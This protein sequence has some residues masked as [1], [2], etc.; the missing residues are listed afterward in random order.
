MDR[1]L[2]V[3]LLLFIRISNTQA[4]IKPGFPCEKIPNFCERVDCVPVDD[5]TTGVLVNGGGNC[6]C[7]PICVTYQ[8]LEESCES[9]NKDEDPEYDKEFIGLTYK[10][11][12][13]CHPGMVCDKSGTKQCYLFIRNGNI[14]NSECFHR[15]AVTDDDVWEVKPDCDFY[16]NFELKRNKGRDTPRTFCVDEDGETIF[17]RIPTGF[18]N[19]TCACS[20][21]VN[22][23]QMA[24]NLLAGNVRCDELGDFT[25]LQCW[26]GVCFCVDPYTKEMTTPAIPMSGISALPCYN[27]TI[28]GDGYYTLCQSELYKWKAIIEELHNKGVNGTLI[29]LPECDFD[30]TYAAMQYDGN[31]QICATRD[32]VQIGSFMHEGVPFV[33][34]NCRCARDSVY[35]DG[36]P[37]SY[38]FDDC[39]NIGE[40]NPQ[41][42]VGEDYYCLDSDGQQTNKSDL[43]TYFIRQDNRDNHY[44]NN[45]SDWEMHQLRRTRRKWATVAFIM[46]TYIAIHYFLMTNHYKLSEPSELTLVSTSNWTHPR[47]KCSKGKVSKEKELL[48]SEIQSTCPYSSFRGLNQK[49]ISYSFY[50]DTDSGYFKGIEI[51]T[52]S[53]K[54]LYPGWTVRLYHDIRPEDVKGMN[55]LCEIVCK[56]PHLDEC[57]VGD[58]NDQFSQIETKFGMLWRFLVLGDPSVDVFGVRDLDSPV[59]EREIDAVNDW[60]S[61]NATFHIMRD[62]PAHVTYILGGMWGARNTNDI[63]KLQKIRNKIITEA[64]SKLKSYDQGLLSMYVWPEAINDMTTVTHRDV[65]NRKD[66]SGESI[67]NGVVKATKI[68]KSSITSHLFLIIAPLLVLFLDILCLK[69]NDDISKW[70]SIP[71]NVSAYINMESIVI[72]VSWIAIQLILF[73]APFGQL[74]EIKSRNGS[75]SKYRVNGFLAFTVISISI[76]LSVYFDF[77]SYLL[78]ISKNSLSFNILSCI[79]SVT[80]AIYMHKKN[81]NSKSDSF[82]TDDFV[83]GEHTRPSICGWD[84]K[85]LLIRSSIIS[86]AVICYA[87]QVSF[88]MTMQK[89]N[90]TNVLLTLL[91]IAFAA[92]ALFFEDNWENFIL[93]NRDG[94]GFLFIYGCLTAA[95]ILATSTLRFICLRN[96]ILPE[97]TIIIRFFII[98]AGYCLYRGSIA[99]KLSFEKQPNH[100][101]FEENFV[102]R[103]EDG[104]SILADGYWG[105]CRNPTYLGILI[106]TFALTA[107]V[108]DNIL[109]YPCFLTTLAFF[110]SRCNKA[111]K[112][113][114]G[115]YG[116]P[117][118]SAYC[119]VVKTKLIKCIY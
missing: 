14:T 69:E 98:V 97:S 74:R 39:S 38:R 112:Y 71:T 23:L 49:V 55:A 37:N 86:W 77:T 17:G 51:N 107:I 96:I 66:T 79:T 78:V 70:S 61:T 28:D 100:P 34:M 106:V 72:Y 57:Y 4:G 8:E 15:Q 94:V 90:S 115:I 46:G 88:Y 111:D 93:L 118:W 2:F 65:P 95:P 22:T 64:H 21:L 91:H 40:Y 67:N 25:Q 85:Q 42:S 20:R 53:V 60:L 109:A 27:E 29:Q 103:N 41:Y 59:Y 24:D 7:C 89:L 63:Q 6:G 56:Y 43:E 18:V 32:G 50:G 31:R 116:Q 80:L 45:S 44:C 87:S 62:N 102:I 9:D 83:F 99:D 82:S 114:E 36:L 110:I 3:S 1:Y 84:I 33:E 73:V 105:H 92:E 13:V 48:N 104:V 108:Y 12:T 75:V 52:K 101:D 68:T 81:R 26:K 76:M 19:T 58:I 117:L 5:C 11:E 35:P 119:Q 47:C 10:F 113:N 54:E 30:G 16:G